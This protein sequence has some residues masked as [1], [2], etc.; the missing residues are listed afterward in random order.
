MFVKLNKGGFKMR[1]KFV[2][3]LAAL[4]LLSSLFA[5]TAAAKSDQAKESL[6]ALGDSIAFGYNLG[7]NNQHPSHEAFPFIMGAD[8][9]MRV[10]DLGIPGWTSDQLL[11]ALK[12][13]E[14]F[15]EAVRH[16]D[17]VTLDIGNNDLLQ[18]LKVSQ[19]N[20]AIIQAYTG[21]MLQN[22]S[23]ILTEVQSLTDAKIVVYNVY[24]A[25][26]VS[27]P[28]HSLSLYLLPQINAGIQAVIYGVA[29]HGTVV[30]ADANTAFGEQQDLYV[31]QGDIHPT[32]EGQKV[33]AEIGL[34]ALG[35]K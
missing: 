24:N 21:K 30:L 23:A 27:D 7:V 20:P 31:R 14:K 11:S 17:V 33:L 26:Q 22:L 13:D 35:L 12:S 5:A 29:L 25:F 16:A 1:K 18:A 10:R 9:D 28:L 34:S 2:P 4:M 3:L 32:V 8:A 6:V 15:R 19:G